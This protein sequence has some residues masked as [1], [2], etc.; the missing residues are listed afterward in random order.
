M[1]EVIRA[2]LSEVILRNGQPALTLFGDHIHLHINAS[3]KF[4]IGGPRG[5][6]G[7]TGRKIRIDTY[8][9]WSAHG[10]G[11]F[12]G[13][14]P[15]KVDRSAADMCSQM[16]KSL[17]KSGLCKRAE[18]QLSYAIG[19]DKPLSLM[20]SLSM[21]LAV[22]QNLNVVFLGGAEEADKIQLMLNLLDKVTSLPLEVAWLSPLSK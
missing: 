9:G 14:D 11:A 6:A 2:T 1:E 13:N 12:S 10:D 3:G 4:I 16:A 18:V 17:I 22:Q 19:V 8:V 21:L 20:V 7:L 5:D 15:N